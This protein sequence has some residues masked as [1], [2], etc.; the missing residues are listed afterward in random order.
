MSTPLNIFQLAADNFES[1]SKQFETFKKNVD[2]RELELALNFLE[3]NLV[4][5]INFKATKL[6]PF[7]ETFQYKNAYELYETEKERKNHFSGRKNQRKGFDGSFE[8]GKKFKYAALNCG[9]IGLRKWGVYCLHFD[10]DK[11]AKERKCVIIK[12][13]SLQKDTIKG[14]EKFYYFEEDA[15]TVNIGKLIND[16]SPKNQVKELICIKIGKLDLTV[17]G[18]KEL[19]CNSED[20]EYMELIFLDGNLKSYVN[21][22]YIWMERAKLTGLNIIKKHK[23]RKIKIKAEIENAN[24]LKQLKAANIELKF[25]EG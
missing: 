8:N 4:F 2:S 17:D 12:R 19:L 11:Y 20:T 9:A 25:V 5:S 6:A 3:E 23:N 13:N 16:L 15:Q 18:F 24:V 21:L 7:L 10:L 14:V 22:A 1:L